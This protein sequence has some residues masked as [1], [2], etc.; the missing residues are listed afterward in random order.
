MTIDI[1]LRMF[2]LCPFHEKP[3]GCFP[4]LASHA[5]EEPTN[6]RRDACLGQILVVDSPEPPEMVWLWSS[7]QVFQAQ[8][9]A[10]S[11]AAACTS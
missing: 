10:A 3:G 4:R 7:R 1:A 6:H 2:R 5:I 9:T 8:S 11:G